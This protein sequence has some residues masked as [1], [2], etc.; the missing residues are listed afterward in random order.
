MN[1]TENERRN[2]VYSIAMKDMNVLSLMLAVVTLVPLFVFN[3]EGIIAAGTKPIFFLAI[4]FWFI[5]HELVHG[6]SYRLSKSVTSQDVAYGAK[7][8]SAVFLWV[9]KKKISKTDA[10]RIY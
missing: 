10:I 4:V 7:L 9:C 1:S 3:R 6:L 2:Y 8:E 5:I